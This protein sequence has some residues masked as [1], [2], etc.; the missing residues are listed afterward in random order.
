MWLVY[1]LGM[2]R[3]GYYHKIHSG[4]PML[5]LGGMSE[6]E[7]TLL[8]QAR[9]GAAKTT[10]VWY[11]LNEFITREHLEG[12]TGDVDSAIISRIHQYLSDGMI[13]YSNSVSVLV[14]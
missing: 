6:E 8:S 5:V 7:K 14:H 12:S 11:W 2:E 9:G 3:T 4:C 13:G 1:W 10:L